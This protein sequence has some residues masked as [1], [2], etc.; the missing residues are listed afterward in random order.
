MTMNEA[1]PALLEDMIATFKERNTTYRDNYLIV[2]KMLAAL[3]PDGITL[4]TPDDFIRYHFVDWLIGKLSRWA[5]TGMAHDDSIKD[6]A[7][8]AAMLAA[9][10]RINNER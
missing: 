8:Y 4:K 6:A 5:N 10:G 1:V 7:V 3:Y 2:G 9:W